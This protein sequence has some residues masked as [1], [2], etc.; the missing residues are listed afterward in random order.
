[1]SEE[2]TIK[3]NTHSNGHSSA[4]S[5]GIIG[6]SSS[7]QSQNHKKNDNTHNYNNSDN[8]KDT[9]TT[10]N[11]YV[12]NTHSFVPVSIKNPLGQPLDIGNKVY[13]IEKKAGYTT[14][15]VVTTAVGQVGETG[16]GIHT[17]TDVAAPMGLLAIGS[18]RT[19]GNF[20]M[21]N[22]MAADL[23]IATKGEFK[24]AL[25][26]INNTLIRNNI[27]PLN[28]K[29]RG[30]QLRMAADNKLKTLS[31]K[32]IYTKEVRTSLTK[33][34]KMGRYTSFAQHK[35][36]KK[37]RF[38]TVHIAT[39]Y[40]KQND[41][42]KGIAF[43]ISATKRGKSALKAGIRT[44]R[45]LAK[46]GRFAAQKAAY[47]S[48][49]LAV[50]I[51]RKTRLNQT[52]IVKKA[53]K[54]AKKVKK[55]TKKVTKVAKKP[56]Q[57]GNRFKSFIKNPFDIKG[58]KNKLYKKTIKKF[59]DK[60]KKK[61]Q[62]TLV[63]K[64]AGLFMRF[65]SKISMAFA[66][67]FAAIASVLKFI[68]IALL[69]IIIVVWII[70]AVVSGIYNWFN[71]SA[72]E[73]EIRNAAI[74]T[75]QECYA[76]DM[77][78]IS[79]LSSTYKNGVSLRF[80]DR[81]NREQ[82]KKHSGNESHAFAQ[83]TNGAEIL[84]MAL[85]RFHDDFEDAGESKVIDYIKQLY[86]GSHEINI[87]ESEST[88]T[89]KDG[90]KIKTKGAIV[91]YRTYYFD[92]LFECSLQSSRNS[93]EMNYDSLN[94]I[95]EVNIQNDMYYNLRKNGFTHEAACAVL[96]NCEIESGFKSSAVS[97]TGNYLGLFQWDKN[98]RWKNL[99]DWCKENGYDGET[100]SGQI[101]FFF[102]EFPSRCGED[103]SEKIKK[104][105]DISIATQEF[106][107]GYEGA[108]ADKGFAYTGTLFNNF[109]GKCLQACQK[110]ID[111]AKKF[112]NQY[113]KYK[114]NNKWKELQSSVG[115]QVATLGLQY[116]GKLH[117][118]YGGVSL[119]DGADCSGF[120]YALYA[121]FGV[122]IPRGSASII[123][124]KSH[125]VLDSI[126]FNKMKPGDVIVESSS[127]SGS[128][129]HVTLY[130][131]DG[132]IIGSNGNN[133]GCFDQDFRSHT[134]GGSN[135]KAN[136]RTCPNDC[137]YTNVT[138]KVFGVYRYVD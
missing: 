114:D 119:T 64:I 120:I 15:R 133:K 96:G 78:Y 41:T 46:V 4:R 29:L 53:K 109:K 99:K 129:R 93:T 47:G 136:G 94:Y 98:G 50:K 131:G 86:Y 56:L 49:L 107:A 97:K 12:P 30:N 34:S 59:K 102:H 122:S 67:I 22:T 40:L 17:F 100:A 106:E 35:S 6:Y 57:L 38:R 5:G 69:I 44:G 54:S 10:R 3:N 135:I 137:G 70:C 123:N 20:F 101:A 132:K 72:T 61:L 90:N 2:K 8:V 16:K 112:S 26:D 37:M 77:R 138:G 124:D 48:A 32:G 134:T 91:T 89:D 74:E 108:I 39:R 85:V 25:K 87:S 130:V 19:M 55:V 127:A 68:F 36:L 18:V 80:E 42:G 1:M 51:A 28:S 71:F 66:K 27:S 125:K 24:E 73:E 84:S 81:K 103:N 128:G 88:N 7:Q 62:N 104:L 75:I 13:N 76:E 43:T 65:G 115:Q 23:G 111:S 110:R 82:Y 11:T 9:N 113:A 116:I 60:I 95:S 118:F 105:T 121:K 83:T 52:K 126:D 92:K 58:K 45:V 33:A 14:S 117:Y 63:G 31:K 21:K 79:S